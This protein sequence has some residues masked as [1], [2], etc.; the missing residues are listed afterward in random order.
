MWKRFIKP[1]LEW[2]GHI[3]AIRAI[4]HTEFFRILLLP[5]VSTVAAAIAG[6]A[7]KMPI[8]WVIVGCSL[9]FMAVTQGLLRADEYRERKNPQNKLKFVKVIIHQ[10]LEGG[11]GE[12]ALVPR[13]R[14]QRRA[15]QR[16]SA[17]TPFSPRNLAKAQVGV[18]LR[19]DATFPISCI[20][21]DADTEVGGKNPP[22]S[23][24]PRERSVAKSGTTFQVLDDPIDMEGARC[25]RME[26]FLN[27]KI[28]YG[29]PGKEVFDLDFDGKLDILMERFGLITGIYSQLK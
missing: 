22:R 28:K 15:L 1:I 20:L 6:V 21:V 4:I 10:D 5:T 11:T 7:Q 16:T 8:I 2:V 24:F 25:E 9:V 19:N 23:K 14:Q 12:L 13:N 18:E 17:I 29:L 26:G 27:M 3:E